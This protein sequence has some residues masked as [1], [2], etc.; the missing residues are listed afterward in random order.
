MIIDTILFNRD[1][2]ALKIRLEELYE[3]VDLFIICE[4]KFTFSGI[5]KDLYLTNNLEKFSKYRNKIII[6]TE[7]K[8]HLTREPFIR[9][10]HQ[11]KAI[12][13]FLKS[14]KVKKADLI[15]HSDCDEIPRRKIII[16]LK[17]DSEVNHLLE[18]RNFTNYLNMELGVWKRARIISGKHY[19][20][21]EE[22]RQDIFLFSLQG[23][24]GFKKYLTRVPHYWTTR[25]YYLWKLPKFYSRPKLELIHD[26]GWHFNNLFSKEVILEKLKASSHTELYLDSSAEKAIQHY[27]TGKDIYFGRQYTKVKIDET[28]PASVYKDIGAWKSYIF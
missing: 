25:N 17:D 13:K 4:S 24:S 22:M 7:N 18:M 19:R 1:F 14:L 23:R 2:E 9:E 5:P 6:I 3:I 11:R 10:I 21:I 26:A 20:S 12:S 8:K 27:S 15:I 16:K 28:Y